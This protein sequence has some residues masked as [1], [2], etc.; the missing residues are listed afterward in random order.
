MSKP[1]V[2]IVMNCLNEE[3]YV[4]QAIDSVFDQTFKDW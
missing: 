4:Q 2:S 3:M 1:K